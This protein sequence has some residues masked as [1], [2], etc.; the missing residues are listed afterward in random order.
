MTDPRFPASGKVIGILQPGYLP[1]LGF[2]EQ[3][4]A[5]DIFVIYDDVQY[6]KHGWRNRNRIKTP[7]GPQWLTVPVQVNF[8]QGPLILEVKINNRENWRKKHLFS[9]RQNY[10]KA[11]FF[12]RYID[13]FT[14][15]YQRDWEYLI[16]LDLH[17]LRHLAAFLGIDPG[18]IVRSSSLEVTGDRITRLIGVCQKLGAATF[19]EGAS[20]RNYIEA[21]AFREQ[22]IEVVYQDYQHPVYPQLYGDFISN[23]SIIDLLFNCGDESLAILTHQISGEPK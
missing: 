22:G 19:Y 4:H 12:S 23:L 17:L 15:V 21:A 14:E 6:D 3:L 20:G 9:I 2:F 18:K 10:A 5:S 16:D 8:S 13:F 7:Q 1:W 11:P